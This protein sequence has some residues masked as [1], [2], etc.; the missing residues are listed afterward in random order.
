MG[1]ARHIGGVAATAQNAD[2][3]T[4]QISS[5]PVR[6]ATLDRDDPLLLGSTVLV[7]GPETARGLIDRL[8]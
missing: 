2:L 8:A 6:G 3:Q 5:A 1:S 4:E 7:F